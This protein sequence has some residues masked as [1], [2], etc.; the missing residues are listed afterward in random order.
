MRKITGKTTNIVAAAVLAASLAALVGLARPA[1]GEDAGGQAAYRDIEQTLGTVPTFFKLFP[2]SGIAGAW[3]EFKSVQLNPKTKLDGK[4]KELIGLAVAAQ[5]PCHYCVYFHTSA[6]KANGAS[7]EEIREA[8]A[9]AAISR[10]WSTVLNGMQVDF[11]T[12]KNETDTVLKVA[13][14]AASTTGKTR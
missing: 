6:A 2:E 7:E 11:D 12:F 9:M 1:S 10:H 14:E 13:G 8:V 4:T 5:I 3:A